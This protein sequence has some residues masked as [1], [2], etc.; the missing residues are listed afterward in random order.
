[1]NYD[2]IWEDLLG[3]IN[4]VC[5]TAKMNQHKYADGNRIKF[6]LKLTYHENIKE[7]VVCI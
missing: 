6:Y 4:I 3:I 1:M 7:F 5:A 2:S